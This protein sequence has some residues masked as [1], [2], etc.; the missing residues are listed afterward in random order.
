LY[1]STNHFLKNTYLRE[2]DVPIKI[3]DMMLQKVRCAR[4]TQFKNIYSSLRL[5]RKLFVQEEHNTLRDCFSQ[6]VLKPLNRDTL[7]EVYIV[8]STMTSLEQLGWNRENLRL[9]GYGKGAVAQYK[10]S[11]T[12]LR[13]YYQTLPAAFVQNSLYTE[14]L[15]KYQLD[16]RLRRPDIILEFQSETCNFKLLEVK[17]SRN[18]QYITESVYKVLGYLKDFERCF[19]STKLPHAILVTWD[20]IETPK[21]INDVITM[22]N[23]RNYQDLIRSQLF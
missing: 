10:H 22:F 11:D 19:V 5:Y 18:R 4:N 16:V 6:G 8:L 21:D 2:I 20:G 9:I 1:Q 12:I 14:L 17:R 7:Y 23:Y 13:I 3:T 15:R